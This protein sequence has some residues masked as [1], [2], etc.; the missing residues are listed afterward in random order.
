MLLP[1]VDPG[2]PTNPAAVNSLRV[3]EF[4]QVEREIAKTIDAVAAKKIDTIESN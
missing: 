2:F 4:R 1:S 3:L